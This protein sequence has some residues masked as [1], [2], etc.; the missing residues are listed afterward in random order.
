MLSE[1]YSWDLYSD[2]GRFVKINADNN[3]ANYNNYNCENDSFQLRRVVFTIGYFVSIWY[4]VK[5]V[6]IHI[7]LSQ[8]KGVAIVCVRWKIIHKVSV[9]CSSE[10]C[11]CIN[12]VQ[13]ET[14]V[15]VS[16]VYSGEYCTHV[17]CAQDDNTTLMSIVYS[18]TVLHSCQLCTLWQHCI[19]V[20]YVHYDNITL[21]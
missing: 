21:M 13:H 15:F 18:M 10:S 4:I 14:A 1:H 12:C 20:I 19:H 2:Q 5:V 16:C 3:P 17:N 7:N 6:C 8:W 9:V 11:I